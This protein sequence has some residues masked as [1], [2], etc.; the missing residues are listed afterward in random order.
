MTERSKAVPPAGQQGKDARSGDQRPSATAPGP[1]ADE[2]DWYLTETFARDPFAADPYPA[3]AGPGPYDQETDAAPGDPV[4]TP[5]A[6]AG[7]AEQRGRTAPGAAEERGTAQE[8]PLSP[9]RA[10]RAEPLDEP[11]VP[12]SRWVR[13]AAGAAA[14]GLAEA[15]P[16]QSLDAPRASSG[17]EYL[18]VEALFSG[19]VGRGA[20]AEAAE[21][22]FVPV[23]EFDP[24]LSAEEIGQP[25][26]PGAAA[27]AA[28]A[29][30][31]ASAPTEPATGEPATGEPAT[32]G[33]AT[34]KVGAAAPAK[35]P[36]KAI[37]PATAPGTPATP[38][39]P[40][41]PAAPAARVK[42]AKNARNARKTKDSSSTG[43]PEA[44]EATGSTDASEAV[45]ANADLDAEA[46]EAAA[47]AEAIAAL[48]A[49]EATEGAAGAAGAAGIEAGAPTDPTGTR[50]KVAGLLD[51]S[52][53]MAAG[54]LVSRGTGF[55]RTMVVA[56]AIGVGTMGD[57]YSAANTL[58]TL[59]YILIGGGALNA[60]FVP[61]LVRSMKQDQD[62]GTAYANRLLT[63]VM[64]GLAGVVFVAVLAAPLL[65]QL[66]SH[67]LMSTPASADTTVALARYCLPTIFF[68]GVH[69][70]MGQI[71]N[72][73][74]R[75]GAMMWTP[76]LNNVVVIFTFAMYLWVFGA[77][78]DSRV[79]PETV[80]PEGLRL[81]GIGTLLG[82][83]VQALAM[84]PYLRAADFHFRPRFDWRGHGLGKAARLAKWTFLF[85]LANQAGYLV[86]TQLA[87]A[88]GSKAAT[89]GYLGV[90]LAA[91][92][93]ALLIWQLP[94]A[95]I[96][97]SV[98]SAV[99]PRLSRAA[100]DGDAA[101][102][103]DDLSYGLRT[104]AV[105]IVPAA[106]LFLA[107]GPQIGGAIY[108]LGNGGS[109]AHGTTAV[110]FMLS[111]FA[112]GLIPYSVQYVLLR[113]FYAYEDTRTPFSNTIW[114]AVAQ[115]AGAL[116]CFLLLPAQWAVTGMALGYGASYVVGV[117]VAVPKLKRRIGDLDTGRIA[118]TYARLA[119]ACVPAALV[120][121]LLALLLGELLD[122]WFGSVL[123]VLVAGAGQVAVFLT[124]AR[125]MR[126]EE[127]NAVIGMVRTRLGR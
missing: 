82:L 42:S 108:G 93:N 84:I 26:G 34:G 107:L 77:F 106:F 6:P 13:P 67:S 103:R 113:G 53:I 99:L 45:T 81:L 100:A 37:D 1:A 86:V 109:A 36:E 43:L 44:A 21:R 48:E 31:D 3:E 59:L 16:E 24:P 29:S 32:G 90:G 110:G 83:A 121:F 112:L 62:G 22:P 98:M 5:A 23:I 4:P 91:Y 85:V 74:G 64:T 69:V 33:G 35:P 9:V 119:I 57:S 71:L 41:D 14:L 11:M 8:Q 56:A 101:A 92:S 58:P 19:S 68:M 28:S 89:A 80:S 88:A 30:A 114:V 40:A 49:A 87:T 55:L 95:V 70:V 18:G 51:S 72:A 61:Q 50:R 38:S 15:E 123:A 54:T 117:A 39:R 66:I 17:G 12:A 2:S 118:K 73:R 94:M 126:I 63:L 115:A 127:L 47:L 7:P 97:V 20:V 125:R 105:A 122:G 52:A 120:G 76:V 78:Q 25:A 27:P 124:L 79:T 116:L 10:D 96:T 111:A 46:A 102:V 65:V 60:V 75:F 104:S